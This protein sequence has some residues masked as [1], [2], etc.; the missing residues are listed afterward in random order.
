[1]KISKH[2]YKVKSINENFENGDDDYI[3]RV[4]CF[5]ELSDGVISHI[6]NF[7]VKL[8]KE[9]KYNVDKIIQESFEREMEIAMSDYT[10]VYQYVNRYYKNEINILEEFNR[11][12]SNLKK[13]RIINNTF[14]PII[15]ENMTKE[16]GV[17]VLETLD[18]FL[19][20]MIENDA[21]FIKILE[22]HDIENIKVKI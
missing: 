2:Y 3:E 16:I 18:K 19:D 8:S 6:H 10:K 21:K 15:G 12:V 13:K 4:P 7:T 20:P 1:M 5:I 9:D 17:H 22:V 11:D 14:I